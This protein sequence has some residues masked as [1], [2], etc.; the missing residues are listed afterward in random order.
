VKADPAQ[1]RV[2]GPARTPRVI[3]RD[4]SSNVPVLQATVQHQAASQEVRKL[5]S[6]YEELV[7]RSPQRSIFAHRWWLEAVAPGMHKILEIRRNDGVRAAWP[8]VYSD[9]DGTRHVCMPPL[10]QKL[11]ILFAPSDAK[12]PELQSTNQELTMELLDQVGDVASF[13]HNFHENYTDWLPFCWR[14]YEQTTRYTY[15]LEDISDI[16]TVWNRLRANHRRDIRRAERL[17]IRV[18]DDLELARFL[19]LNRKTFT[20]QGRQPLASDEVIYRLDAACCSNA[21]RKIFAGVDSQGRVH[22]AVYIVWADQTAYY[23]MGGS[24]PEFRASGAQM[25]ALWEAVKFTSSVVRRFDFE[26]SM[27]PHVEHTFRGFGAKQLPY[28]SISK[29][30]PPPASLSDFVKAS[31]RFRWEKMRRALRQQFSRKQ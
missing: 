3:A 13:R 31:I 27:L 9:G 29:L 25:S 2:S 16:A 18:K 17:G 23:L 26:G 12:L 4:V 21:G 15:V 24:E 14:G 22:A 11:G 28:F 30:P 7:Q 10:T 5:P 6:T 8:V 20:R 1:I 19:E